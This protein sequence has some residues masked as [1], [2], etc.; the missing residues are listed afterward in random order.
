MG[1]NNDKYDNKASTDLFNSIVFNHNSFN[2]EEEKY[3]S[4]KL[5]KKK[6]FKLY[7]INNSWEIPFNSNIFN[8]IKEKNFQFNLFCQTLYKKIG[9]II[10]FNKN[11]KKSLNKIKIILNK[12][13]DSNDIEIYELIQKYFFIYLLDE[14]QTEIFNK[15]LSYIKQG[16][17]N[18]PLI[19]FVKK[20]K[21]NQEFDEK[22][23]KFYSFNVDD[24]NLFSNVLLNFINEKKKEEDKLYK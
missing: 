12:V 15:I 19:V 11:N 21:M 18:L 17:N 23:I 7:N 5:E 1:N 16:K 2:N 8:N 24:V 9:I 20:D 13:N 22:A 4:C 3:N 14:S 10:L 6:N